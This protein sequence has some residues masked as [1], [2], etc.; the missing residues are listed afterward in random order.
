[1]RALRDVPAEQEVDA[2]FGESA[3]AVFEKVYYPVPPILHENAREQVE[4]SFEIGGRQVFGEVV[5]PVFR[6]ALDGGQN[7]VFASRGDFL[8]FFL[9]PRVEVADEVVSY[10]NAVEPVGVVERARLFYGLGEL[11]LDFGEVGLDFLYAVVGCGFVEFFRQ[12]YF[13]LGLPVEEVFAQDFLLGLHLLL[14]CAQNV[15]LALGLGARHAGIAEERF[16]CLVPPRPVRLLRRLVF[17]GELLFRNGR[18]FRHIPEKLPEKRLELYCAR[19]KVGLFFEIRHYELPA[20]LHLLFKIFA[21]G[22]VADEKVVV[23]ENFELI[24]AE[25]RIHLVPRLSLKVYY[26]LLRRVVV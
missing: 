23:L 26:E 22:A 6:V 14:F 10:P 18:V 5:Q 3:L 8:D 9:L 4:E 24:D 12:K 20:V 19:G 13:F 25:G 1:M 21:V 2:L 16:F 11:L 17:F 7:D 15:G